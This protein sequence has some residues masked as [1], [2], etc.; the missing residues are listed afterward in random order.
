MNV[1]IKYRP[2]WRPQKLKLKRSI[3]N[4]SRFFLKYQIFQVK[5]PAI[6]IR[7]L[8]HK[9]FYDAAEF[10]DKRNH[11]TL[12]EAVVTL[13]SCKHLSIAALA[14]N[15]ESTALIKNNIKRIARLFGNSSTQNAA[16]QYYKTMA[17]NN[18]SNNL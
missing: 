17:K 11:K 9:T 14:R 4:P 12:I 10:I 7:K 18:I 1:L 2:I 8:L 3:D 5:E 15:L 16:L 13:S 6:H